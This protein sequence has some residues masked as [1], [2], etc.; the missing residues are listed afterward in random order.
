MQHR[1]WLRYTV[2][3]IGLILVVA[4][5]LILLGVPLLIAAAAGV[6]VAGIASFLW[7]GRLRGD[8]SA[9][10]ATARDARRA[11]AGDPD[12]ETEDRIA[13]ELPPDAS[14]GQEAD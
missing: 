2:V 8:F 13:A 6:L 12:A 5:V 3:R 1:A 11:R 9:E 10:I 14:P 7:L 4:A